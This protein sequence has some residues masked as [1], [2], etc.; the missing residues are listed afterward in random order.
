MGWITNPHRH[1]SRKFHAERKAREPGPPAP[2]EFVAPTP[3]WMLVKQI[4]S[5]PTRLVIESGGYYYQD[6][7]SYLKDLIAT[8]RDVVESRGEEYVVDVAVYA[9]RNGLVKDTPLI[10]AQLL[11]S[12]NIYRI[13][14]EYPPH[15]VHRFMEIARKARGYTGTGYGRRKKRAVASW[16][17]HAFAEVDERAE[18]IAMRYRRHL[19]DILRATHPRPETSEQNALYKWILRKGEPPTERIRVYEEILG[20]RYGPEE[21]VEKA[22][23]YRLPYELVRSNIPHSR[24]SAES[25]YRVMLELASGPAI[26]LA[27][28]GIYDRLGRDAALEIVSRR[29][30]SIPLHHLY[31]ALFRMWG[32]DPEFVGEA[33]RVA[34]RSRRFR[35]FLG[36]VERYGFGRSILLVDVSF[37]MSSVI[38][39]ARMVAYVLRD[40]AVETYAFSTIYERDIKRIELASIGDAVNE[41]NPG[42]GTPL[43]EALDHASR[44]VDETDASSVLVITDEM[45]NASE[46]AA[47]TYK[48]SKPMLIFNPTP[49]PAEHILKEKGRVVG[50]PGST[51]D[52]VKAGMQYV[53]L[54]EIVQSDGV[55]KL[56]EAV[57]RGARL[58]I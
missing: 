42:G 26:G 4:Y 6:L 38:D 2:D 33:D 19:A 39:I 29:V 23:E 55:E 21:A 52:G 31:R 45:E 12:E 37:S 16:L 35:E 41:L 49:Y 7:E 27:L 24:I 3:E 20:G 14:V 5:H 18:Y 8:V 25:Y 1:R 48:S 32:R 57:K 36:E 54:R 50:V 56:V 34:R 47:E 17:N 46:R 58:A 13:L 40:A 28:S 53:M 51:L 15:L 22:L 9:R 10:A 30:E 44:R 11:S 43:Y